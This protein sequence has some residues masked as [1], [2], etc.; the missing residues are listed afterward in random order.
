M[1]LCVSGY[2]VILYRNTKKMSVDEKSGI[3]FKVNVQ[4]LREEGD[5]LIEGETTKEENLRKEIEETVGVSEWE[6]IIDRF[7][8]LTPLETKMEVRPFLPLFKWQ[9]SWPK[10]YPCPDV[11]T[12]KGSFISV[13]RLSRKMERE[14]F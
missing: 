11:E 8:G 1:F 7:P 5:W 13:F 2:S 12:Q 10:E 9:P 6:M 4:I 14:K 3:P